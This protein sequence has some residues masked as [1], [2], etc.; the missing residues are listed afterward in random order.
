MK[1]FIHSM[2][3]KIAMMTRPEN[4]VREY[5]LASDPPKQPTRFDTQAIC[6]ITIR[7]A[8]NGRVLEATWVKRNNTVPPRGNMNHE[9]I[10][11]SIFLVAEGQNL[12]EAVAA[13]L[14]DQALQ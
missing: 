1:A 6:S 13:L 7:P 4:N 8:M 2:A 12:A 3:K 14:V 10:F 5:E 11:S 9:Q